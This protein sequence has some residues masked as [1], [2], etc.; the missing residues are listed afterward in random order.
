MMRRVIAMWPRDTL[1]LR[2][3]RGARRLGRRRGTVLFGPV[4]A[5][6][7]ESREQHKAGDA[8]L[9]R[10]YRAPRTILATSAR[11]TWLCRRFGDNVISALG[12]DL[13]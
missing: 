2:I 11:M 12:C 10:L 7:R 3:A 13:R 4:S 1:M 8:H 5:G 9:A 6:D